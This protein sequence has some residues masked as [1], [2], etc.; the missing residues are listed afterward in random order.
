M[1]ALER[2]GE[3]VPE[4][5]IRQKLTA[6]SVST[7]GRLLKGIRTRFKPRGMV[8]TKPGTLLKKSIAVRTG[9]EWTDD[10]PGF[11]EADLVYKSDA[12]HSLEFKCCIR[13]NRNT[14]C[15]GKISAIWRP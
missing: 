2:H 8:T 11:F 4:T 15:K 3:W 1:E 6:M 13:K 10:R 12:T 5:S 9:T 7:C 14:Q